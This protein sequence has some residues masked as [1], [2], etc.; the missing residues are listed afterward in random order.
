MRTART[1]M[2][3][4]SESIFLRQEQGRD[5]PV[6]LRD[7]VEL[8]IGHLVDRKDALVVLGGVVVGAPVLG[9]DVTPVAA[10]VAAKQVQ[11]RQAAAGE[12]RESGG[13]G[14]KLPQWEQRLGL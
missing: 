8:P 11:R 9:V 2:K 14:D 13:R 7:H 12:R 10:G 3:G 6:P 5:R 1:A 4:L